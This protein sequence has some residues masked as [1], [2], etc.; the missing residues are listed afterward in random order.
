MPNESDHVQITYLLRA[1]LDRAWQAISDAR[2]FETWFGA[3]IAGQFAAGA[4]LT[5][6]IT[7]TNTH[8]GIGRAQ[9]PCRGSPFE[10]SIDSVALLAG[11]IDLRPPAARC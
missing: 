11:A 7:A 8:P 10:I 1:P 3:E 5:G 4:R 6:R 9:R 2:Q